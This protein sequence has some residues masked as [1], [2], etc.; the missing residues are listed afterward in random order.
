MSKMNP[1]FTLAESALQKLYA[2]GVR[3]FC[4][5]AGARNAPLVHLLSQA[6]GIKIYRFFEER[7]A[8]FFALGRMQ[9]SAYP[10]AVLTTSG[11]AVAELLPA[12]IEAFYQGLPLILVSADRPKSYRGSGAPQSMEQVGIFSHYVEISLDLD[13]EFP[14]EELN[15]SQKKPMHW[16]LCFDEPLLENAPTEF[17]IAQGSDYAEP[18]SA[19]TRS[20]YTPASE[21]EPTVTASSLRDHSVESASEPNSTGSNAA[22][23]RSEELISQD[24][25]NLALQDFSKSCRKPLIILGELDVW[26]QESVS[27]VLQDLSCPIYAE[28]LSGLREDPALQDLMLK[29]GERVLQTAFSSKHCDGVL[30]LGGVPSLRF[31]RDLEL[32]FKEVPVLNFSNRN[33]SGLARKDAAVLPLKTLDQLLEM[34]FKTFREQAELMSF[35]RK[36]SLALQSLLEKFPHSE[37][38]WVQKL[39]RE[40]PEASHLFLGNSLPIREWDLAATR[41]YKRIRTFGNRGMNGIDGLISTFLGTC[42]VERK[43]F[44]LIGDLSALYD[45]SAPWILPQMETQDLGILVINNGGGKIFSRVFKDPDFENQHSL[46]FKA[47]AELWNLEYSRPAPSEINLKR[48]K[49]PAVLE[50]CPEDQQTKDFWTHYDQL[51]S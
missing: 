35:D 14:G 2:L 25:H 44:I 29:S 9:V 3:E 11:T 17:L 15:W 48:L 16:N 5:C 21:F 28:A 30:R 6:K 41:D 43:N 13:Q 8:A 46:N 24:S 45:L 20:F 36:M 47:F 42:E 37:P 33:L 1:N 51:W 7:S 49:T 34:G 12:T 40:L 38:A 4:L 18:K 23:L 31:W 39:S 32:K 19:P 22:R 27:L 50:I 10:V 26:D